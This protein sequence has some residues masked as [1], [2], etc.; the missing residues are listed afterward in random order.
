MKKISF[1]F[2]IA[3]IFTALII[4]TT[5]LIISFNYLRSVEIVGDSSDRITSFASQRIISQTLNFLYTGQEAVDLLNGYLDFNDL[6]EDQE[7]I[8]RFMWN[9]LNKKTNLASLYIGDSL[10]SFYQ[11]RKE[12]ELASGAILRST[13]GSQVSRWTRRNQ[14]YQVLDE[15]YP[16]PLADSYDP[17]DRLWYQNAFPNQF[18]WT[19]LYIFSSTGEPGITVSIPFI[20]DGRNVGVIAADISLL[21][22]SSFLEENKVGK[23]GLIF[24]FNEGGRIVAYPNAEQAVKNGLPADIRDLE[25]SFVL[26]GYKQYI[27]SLKEQID[28]ATEEVDQHFSRLDFREGNRDYIASFQE[29]P[30]SFGRNWIIGSIIPDDEVFGPVRSIILQTILISLGIVIISLIF[31]SMLTKSIAEP[32]VELTEVAERISDLYL[33]VAIP[34]GSYI[35]EIYIMQSAMMGMRG[36]L[37][38]FA[39]YIPRDLVRELIQEGEEASLGG[40]EK[41]LTIFLATSQAS[42]EFLNPFR[43]RS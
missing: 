7:E 23:E 37:S 30:E 26:S 24:I 5:T 20:K 40:T 19:N 18:Y 33:D 34:T 25:D 17:R 2:N 9:L 1:R 35:K 6:E 4:G 29:F 36:G 43:L 41:N 39:K 10:G 28:P 27:E 3:A 16:S 11:V 32:I 14:D 21:K 15:D 38:A 12:P 31:I 13:D 8:F 42:P 22:L